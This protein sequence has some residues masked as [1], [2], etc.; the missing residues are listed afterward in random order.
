[1]KR[2]EDVLMSVELVKEGWLELDDADEP[3][4]A[5]EAEEERGRWS[6]VLQAEQERWVREGW[7]GQGGGRDDGWDVGMF[8]ILV[9]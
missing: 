6:L 8:E 5:V 4:C 9:V 1:M 3:R 7:G 2:R